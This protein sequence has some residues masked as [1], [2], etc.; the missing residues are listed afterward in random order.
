MP[1]A[2]VCRDA[3]SLPTHV[4]TPGMEES[5]HCPSQ[6]GV[7]K[8]EARSVFVAVCTYQLGIIGRQLETALTTTYLAPL[9]VVVVVVVVVKSDVQKHGEFVYQSSVKRKGILPFPPPPAPD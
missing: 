3:R 4:F 1:R 8:H 5:S 7:L 6:G 2:G 9:I